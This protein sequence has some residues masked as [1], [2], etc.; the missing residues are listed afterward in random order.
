[1]N[2]NEKIAI[3]TTEFQKPQWHPARRMQR[4]A[5]VGGWPQKKVRAAFCRRNHLLHP[6]S[7]NLLLGRERQWT[8]AQPDPSGARPKKQKLSHLDFFKHPLTIYFNSL[9]LQRLKT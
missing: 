6:N 8:P 4:A 9:D 3:G 5:D 1:M 7:P 2:Q